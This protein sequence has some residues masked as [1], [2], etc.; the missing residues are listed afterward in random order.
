MKSANHGRSELTSEKKN[1]ERQPDE[2]KGVTARSTTNGQAKNGKKNGVPPAEEKNG[3]TKNAAKE[4]E[5]KAAKKTGKEKPTKPARPER[6]TLGYR[7]FDENESHFPCAALVLP[8]VPRLKQWVGWMSELPEHAECAWRAERLLL[9]FDSHLYSEW[10]EIDADDPVGA[11][12][13]WR[14]D[15]PLFDLGPVSLMMASERLKEGGS[16]AGGQAITEA[17]GLIVPREVTAIEAQ[18]N[19]ATRAENDQGAPPETEGNVAPKPNGA[20]K[21]KKQ[22]GE[23]Q[24]APKP[25]HLMKAA[26]HPK[27]IHAKPSMP[28]RSQSHGLRAKPATKQTKRA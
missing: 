9:G 20:S 3:E 1:G 10:G 16:G 15:R 26:K 21:S 11:P 5:P 14:P 25:T 2:G 13:K 17:A 18:A 6:R 23:S 27:A 12:I 4:D 24:P 8:D 7:A 19:G 28:K 22:I